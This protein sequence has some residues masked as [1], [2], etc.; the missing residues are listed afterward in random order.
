[1]TTTTYYLG[2]RVQ[3]STPPQR[4]P[5]FTLIMPQKAVNRLH[6]SLGEGRSCCPFAFAPAKIRT[7]I[8]RAWQRAL[9][10][11]NARRGHPSCMHCKPALRRK[12]SGFKK[13]RF[14]CSGPTRV[15]NIGSLPESQPQQ[16]RACLRDS[17]CKHGQRP[18]DRNPL[19]YSM[20]HL[21]LLIVT[22]QHSIII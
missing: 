10:S 9:I 1:M 13:V 16:L 14:K 8:L 11:V 6:V 20:H 4:L 12:G 7:Y 5:E 17:E 3:G 22:P 2:F 15:P 21:T 19:P 18:L